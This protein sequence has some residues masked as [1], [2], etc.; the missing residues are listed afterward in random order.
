[1]TNETASAEANEQQ[2]AGSA[3]T[4]RN[5]V[6]VVHGM[7]DQRPLDTLKGFV[8]T[9]LRRKSDRTWDYYYSRP[10]EVTGSFEARRFIARPLGGMPPKQCQTEV[11]EYHWSYLMTGNRF[12]D[13]IPS[14]VRLL[15][16]RPRN[17]PTGLFG[18]WRLAWG[19]VAVLAVLA[20][21]GYLAKDH[22]P[23]W[24]SAVLS[25]VLVVALVGAA[26]RAVRSFITSS[27]VDVVR[28]L[29]TSPRSYAARR[30]IRGGLVD[31]LRALHDEDRYSR[32][33]VVAHSLG[34]F[35]AY[36]GL[37]SLW[38]Q[39][40]ELHAGP[41]GPA[42]GARLPLEG[43]AALE[44]AAHRLLNPL[45]AQGPSPGGQQSIPA[46]APQ[47]SA[48]TSSE[49]PDP[50]TDFQNKQFELWRGLR[51]QGNPWRITDFVSV[52]TPMYF[53]DVLVTHP[54]LF[55]GLRK[56]SPTDARTAFDAMMRGGELV[57]C[58][59]RSETL[60]VEGPVASPDDTP[61]P[62][63]SWRYG[64]RQ[65]L[66]SQSMF[67]VVRWT[68]IWFPVKRG[69]LQGDWFGGPLQDLFGPGIR[70]VPVQG[71]VPGRLARWGRA[72]SRYFTYPND[73]DPEDVA[74]QIRLA[75]NLGVYT[76]L[77]PLLNAPA[78]DLR[79][80][81]ARLNSRPGNQGV[82]ATESPQGSD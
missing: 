7:G 76:E 77:V 36:D 38:A 71:N 39:V 69:S 55:S 50:L 80:R 34:A 18:V 60:P 23:A 70:D 59:P 67:A 15:L 22:F 17:V 72:H 29:D 48:A 1:M 61:R 16:R 40:H 30:A 81:G 20:I 82:D 19:V 73:D 79:T 2:Q 14:T 10:A 74:H 53:A 51:R 54:R 4:I 62:G 3:S 32:I 68:N 45:A 43:L 52:G 11:F 25:S 28:Y 37:S 24:V 26:W 65:V 47:G 13:V 75:L 33:I 9:A 64:K 42:D 27:F 12:S 57:R 8:H 46:T 58:P 66:G 78:P 49:Q 56:A 6:V 63:Y 44:T 21:G 35:I 41:P 31:L 5:A